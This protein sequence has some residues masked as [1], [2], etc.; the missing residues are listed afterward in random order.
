[1]MSILRP[2]R[3]YFLPSRTMGRYIG[4]VFFVR[5]LGLV[6][7]VVVVLQMLDLLAQ[8]DAILAAPGNGDA[9]LWRYIGLRFPELLSRFIPFSALLAVLLTLSSLSQHSEIVVMKASGMSAHRIL[10]PL[11][12]ASAAI[13][14][15]HFILDQK[16]VAPS[17]A[18]LEYWKRFDYASD[19]PP[20]P[21]ILDDLWLVD[22]NALV[23]VKAV[24]RSGSR[25]ILDKVTIYQRNEQGQLAGI[26]RADFAWHT[27]GAWTLYAV[28][29]FDAETHAITTEPSL[30]W[31]LQS[32]PE[33]FFS[34]RVI[35]EQLSF[36]RLEEQ[37]DQL[38]AEG[39]PVA[40][41]QAALY[42]KIAGPLATLLMPILGAIAGFGAQRGGKIFARVAAGMG[43][44]FAFFV[45]D[46]FMLAMGKFGAAPAFLAAF[47]P[48]LI[49]TSLGLAVIFYSEE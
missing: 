30:P 23:L 46:N 9:E 28:R 43:L 2:L 34:L 35:P 19:L 27:D 36:S 4:K 44:G 24:S 14:V 37:I 32:P 33:R 8:S 13:S 17:T 29:R 40:E 20:A 25:V 31:T 45:A 49:F 6:I 12:L 10:L 47:G 5:F 18:E 48:M 1:M 3:R 42:Q 7:G 15:V 41:L 22:G 39:K 16:L 21:D 11:L 38:K 26:V